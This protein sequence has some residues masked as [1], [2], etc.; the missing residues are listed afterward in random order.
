MGSEPLSFQMMGFRAVA[1]P[2][3]AGMPDHC[4]DELELNYFSHGTLTYLLGGHLRTLPA[5]HFCLFWGGVPHRIVETQD[6]QGFA[7]LTVPLSWLLSWQVPEPFM[8][9]LMTGA[10][11]H[12]PAPLPEDPLLLAR[13]CHDLE[14]TDAPHRRLVELEVEARVTRFALSH[15]EPLGYA[16]V[17]L[18][19]QLDKVAAMAHFLAERYTEPVGV[20]QVAA[21]VALH[22]NYAM[23]LFK[24]HY[25]V[26]LTTYLT[27]LRV[28][29]AQ[30]SLL[31]SSG[32]VLEIGLDAGFT[33]VSRFY[34]AFRKASGV[35]PQQYRKLHRSANRPSG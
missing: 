15:P 31:S 10:L 19:R 20:A 24:K 21:H 4:H 33:S 16:P 23:N 22:P 32:S 29:R 1:G 30:H 8:K 2:P 9:R 13:W 18:S 17:S 25:G 27:Q 14:H 6:L 11:F 7:W 26:T 12:D 3:A 5:G 28:S 35:T 34:E